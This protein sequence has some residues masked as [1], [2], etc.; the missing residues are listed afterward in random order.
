MRGYYDKL[1][2]ALKDE[3]T[4][5]FPVVPNDS[6]LYA[7]QRDSNK[8]HPVLAMMNTVGLNNVC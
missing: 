1:R 6:T 3:P 7:L 4:P 8:D 2:V 5:M